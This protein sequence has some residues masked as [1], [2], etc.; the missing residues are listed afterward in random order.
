[1]R[2]SDI[3]DSE[4]GAFIA[5]SRRAGER[6]DL[7]Q[8]GGG[9]TS[10]KLADGTMLIKSSG[11]HLSDLSP[12]HG[13][14]RVD[15]GA[16]LRVLDDPSL[17]AVPDKRQRDAEAAKRLLACVRDS[18]SRPSIETFLH[19]LLD[20]YTLHTH[21]LAVNAVACRSDWKDV[22]A[23]AAGADAAFVPYG[24]PGFELALLLKT[25]VDDHV[26]LKG[27]KPRTLFLQNHGLIT[28]ADD[29]DAAVAATESV[30][31]A[32]EQVIGADLGP[33][34]LTNRISSLV[35]E[36]GGPPVVSYL[37]RDSELQKLAR[38]HRHLFFAPPF[39]PDGMVYCGAAAVEISSLDD[40][41]PVV[42]YRR[43]F[44]E[45]P[46]VV[47]YGDRIFLTGLNVRKAREAE[48]VF[49]FQVLALSY[50]GGGAC[51][52]SAEELN[53]LGNWEAEQYRRKQ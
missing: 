5:L 29:A 36:G 40:R 27:R 35:N 22:L 34:K 33:Y 53:Y 37:S 38:T 13:Y 45:A 4:T 24:T 3:L 49:K 6:F 39:C 11:A 14:T 20:R 9:N 52:L 7:I 50:A 46:R 41:E 25:T 17:A 28:S 51:S 26:R 42:R 1:M 31:T 48:E 18:G 32:L 23:A 30:L 15:L 8:A 47:L 10:V 16:V 19:A 21:P 12:G 44:G 43:Q 2:S